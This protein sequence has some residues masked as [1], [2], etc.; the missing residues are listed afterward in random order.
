[1]HE[2]DPTHAGASPTDSC[3]QRRLQGKLIEAGEGASWREYLLRLNE[4]GGQSGQEIAWILRTAYGISV[5]QAT[6]CRWLRQAREETSR[7]PE[8]DRA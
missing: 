7:M 5:N 6:A 3:L 8:A 1:M 2:A 4:T